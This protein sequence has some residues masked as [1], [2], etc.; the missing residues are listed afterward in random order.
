M[1]TTPEQEMSNMKNTM[2]SLTLANTLDQSSKRRVEVS[3]QQTVKEAVHG[4]NPTGLASFDVYDG[5]G[6]VVS[7]QPVVH[8]AESTLYIGV[9]AVVGGGVPRERLGELQ[10]EYPSIQPVKQWTDRKQSKMFL[11]RFPSNGR[12]E[13]GFWEVV[14]HCPDAGRALMHAYV[15]NF[16]EISGHVGVS[17]FASPPSIH[18]ATGAGNGFIPGSSTTRG[19]WVCHGDIKPHLDRLGNDPIARVGAY[20]NHI[21]NLLNQ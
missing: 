15:L 5:L 19:H 21:Q 9:Q 17:L 14:I 13:S 7:H 6:N 1:R 16:N 10:I 12:T 4:Q 11:V 8:H 20:I 3:S 18:Y 2:I